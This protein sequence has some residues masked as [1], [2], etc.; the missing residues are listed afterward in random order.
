MM[1]TGR[2]AR[3]PSAP[4]RRGRLV[5]VLAATALLASACGG[6][7][8][9]G[10]AAPAPSPGTAAD[11]P[12][13]VGQ[14]AEPASLDPHAVT[15]V[16]DFRINV[17]LYDGLV[18]YDDDSLNVEPALATDWTVSDDGLTYTFTLREG[19]TFHDGSTF[20]AD[21]VVF[22]FER[23][24]DEDHPYHGTGPFPLAGQFYGNL[25]SIVA[26][27]SSEVV[28]TLSSP[29]APFLSNLAYPSGLIIS[30]AAVMEH[31]QDVGRNPSG[32]GPYRFVEWRSNE[33]VTLERN[34]DYWDG[35]PPVSGVVFRP[36]VEA[37]TRVNELF[38]GGVDLIVEVPPDELA[39]LRADA[40]YTVYEQAGPHVWF[41]I[42][43]LLEAPFDDVRVRQAANH[44]ID[45]QSLVDDV[46][47]GTA[48]VA[49]S[50]TPP[51][52]GSAHNPDITG[53]D[54]DPER[55]RQ[56]LAEAGYPDGVDVTF[57]VTEGGSGMLDPVPMGEAIQA[58]LRAVG[59]NASIQTYE[60]N[61]FLG[62]VNP[63]LQGKADMAQMAWMTADPDTLPFLTLRTN[64]WPD[65]G[66]FN[67]GYYSNPEVD[68]LLE[69][70]QVET[71]PAE[72]DRLYRA[73]QE[74]VV[75]DAPWVF[76]ANW[77]Q[78]AASSSALTGFD[79][80]PSFLLR[81]N[82]AALG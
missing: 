80:H 60:W 14:V 37:T 35:P 66:G 21:A 4:N 77:K 63:G 13:V 52:F 72:R 31:G 16:N 30:P 28:M 59:I 46:L 26:N 42:L 57:Y 10:G 68:R 22:N 15:A 24:L 5:A 69:A 27:G 67:S 75:E 73:M 8:A 32:T 7:D 29:F 12:V 74:I 44:A 23:M 36:I 33:R 25:D 3:R 45:R 71:D 20:D 49:N 48:T 50:P 54:Y 34:A 51:A 79:V 39:G 82:R 78:N 43:N 65:A 62:E 41:L 19:V 38:T 53:Y 40:N 2:A 47:Q 55:A 6:S 1:T 64:A 58:D 56:L 9:D 18:R 81:L 61:S 70:A 17:N 76:V 11:R